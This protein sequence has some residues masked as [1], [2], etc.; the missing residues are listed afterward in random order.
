MRKAP[1]FEERYSAVVSSCASRM[2]LRPA[3]DATRSEF[4][5][6]GEHVALSADRRVVWSAIAQRR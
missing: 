1:C 2:L 3:R 4:G 5:W 6:L